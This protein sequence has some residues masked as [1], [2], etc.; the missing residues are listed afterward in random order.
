MIL[1]NIELDLVRHLR[2]TL[3]SHNILNVSRGFKVEKPENLKLEGIS[4]I[5]HFIRDRFISIQPCSVIFF[6]ESALAN[7]NEKTFNILTQSI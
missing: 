1:F 2:R 5:L 4:C 6:F 7:S 3:L